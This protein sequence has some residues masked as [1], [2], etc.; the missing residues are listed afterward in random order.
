M[1]PSGGESNVWNERDS[2]DIAKN[3]SQPT[4]KNV[5]EWLLTTALRWD[6]FSLVIQMYFKLQ[7]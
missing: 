6:L 2:I 4:S 5:M 1:P 7:F 3:L